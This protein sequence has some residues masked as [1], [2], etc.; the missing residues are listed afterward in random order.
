MIKITNFYSIQKRFNNDSLT[1]NMQKNPPYK[2]KTLKNLFNIN[3]FKYTIKLF[4]LKR[5]VIPRV[6]LIK[7]F[8]N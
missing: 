7:L 2:S 3:Q 5:Y 6:P 1:S 4:N 8:D